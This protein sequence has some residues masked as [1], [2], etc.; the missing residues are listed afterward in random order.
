LA[1][2]HNAIAAGVDIVD[3][4]TYADEAALEAIAERGIFVVPSL[5]QPRQHLPPARRGRGNDRAGPAHRPE[6]GFLRTK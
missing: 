2:I 5:Y 1:D 3:H 4:A 6:P